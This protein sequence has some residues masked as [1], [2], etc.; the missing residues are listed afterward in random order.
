[1]TEQL[2]AFQKEFVRRALAPGIDVAG[3]SI[4]RGNGKSWLAA[5]LLTRCLTPGDALHVAGAEYLLCAASIEQGWST[6]SFAT[7]LSRRADTR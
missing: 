5:H 4:P 7:S 2:R 6:D 1:M 3:L